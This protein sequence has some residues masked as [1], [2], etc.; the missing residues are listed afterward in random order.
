MN[1]CNK[2]IQAVR[3]RFLLVLLLS[4]LLSAC[5]SSGDEVESQLV[6]EAKK[7]SFT[8]DLH[9]V[10]VLDAVKSHMISSGIEGA[11]GTIIYL[12]DDGEWVEKGTP[13][14]RFDR[15]LFEKEVDELESQVKSYTAAVKA[16]EQVVAFERNQVRREVIS[17]RYGESVA[18][19]ELKRLEEG[20]GPLK[21]TTLEEEHEK[22]ALELKRYQSFLQELESFQEKGFDN[23]SEISSTREKVAAFTKELA[24]V[25]KRYETYKNHVLPALVESGRAKV[26]NASLLLQQTEQ[27]G[28]YKIAKANASLLQVK[29]VLETKKSA[30]AKARFKLEQTEIKAPFAG[31]VIHYKTFRNGEKRKPR[32]GD[33]VFMN[34]PI[35]YLPDVSKMMVKTQAREVDLHKIALG[36]KGRIVVDAYP[37]AQLTG[38]LSFIGSLATAEDSGKSFEKYFQVLFEINETDTRLRPG[39]SCRISIEV[40]SLQ[41]VLS[42]P[43]QAVFADREQQFCFVRKGSGYV[44]RKVLVG[45]QNQEFI[46]IL[47]G[48]AAG[49]EVSLVRQEI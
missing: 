12:V 15:A 2:T 41:D 13:L 39:M 49:E 16:A 36:Q 38:A 28:K 14:V 5:S 35:L 6:A 26:Q 7:R 1:R 34:Q 42:I 45:K 3:G 22:V 4:L 47:D 46:E 31:I 32:E 29:G 33:S 18:S 21:L 20:D 17:A 8:I 44:V 11:N 30:L 37:D 25:T 43:V 48:L 27:G 24:S 19:L 9:I 10:G 40:E 23:P